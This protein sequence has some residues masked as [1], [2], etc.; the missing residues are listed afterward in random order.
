LQ[1]QKEMPPLSSEE[2]DFHEE[3]DRQHAA[4]LALHRE[5]TNL[6]AEL[7]EARSQMRRAGVPYAPDVGKVSLS[8]APSSDRD[9]EPSEAIAPSAAERCENAGSVSEAGVRSGSY[10]DMVVN[11]AVGANHIAPD[12]P[13]GRRPPPHRP[14]EVEE[15]CEATAGGRGGL[16]GFISGVP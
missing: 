16:W 1:K 10:E 6:K 7:T 14:V 12:Q 3:D 2:K 4:L 15:T 9:F 5:V 13:A 8:P 11:G